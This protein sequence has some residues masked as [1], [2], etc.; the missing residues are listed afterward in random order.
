MKKCIWSISLYS[1]DEKTNLL[2]IKDY[3][4]ISEIQKEFKLNKSFLYEC[5]SKKK[6]NTNSRK[7]N[8]LKKYKRLLIN[9]K[10]YKKSGEYIT[11]TFNI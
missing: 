10:T 6:Y 2:F 3:N 4:N 1:D 11:T 8:T 7:I 5:C 9:K